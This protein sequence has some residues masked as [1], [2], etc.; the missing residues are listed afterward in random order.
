VKL[1]ELRPLDGLNVDDSPW[2]P[3]YEKS[4]GFIIRAETE[5]QARQ[6]ATEMSGKETR[7]NKDAWLNPNLSS[8]NELLPD[9]EAGFIMRDFKTAL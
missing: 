3:F 5:K 9:G 1:Y 2:L 7:K 8:C 4:F 6:I